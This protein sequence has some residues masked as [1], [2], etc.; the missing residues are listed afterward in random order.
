[1]WF[2]VVPVADALGAILAHGVHHAGSRFAKGRVIS[3][4]D[5][6][7][8]RLSG[9]E[10]ITVA[11]LEEGDV[12]E[13]AAASRLATRLAGANLMVSAA[14]TGRVNL[15]AARD[16]IA[17]IDAATINALNRVD[18]AVTIAT[19]PPYTPVLKGQMLATI[20]IIPFGVPE[21][22]ISN[23]EWM[24][25]G[26]GPVSLAPWAGLSAGLIQTVLPGTKPSVLD[27]S[28]AVTAARMAGIGGTL[29]GDVRVAHAVEPLA[30]ALRTAEGAI[31]LIIGAS[32]ITDRRDVIPAAIEAAGGTVLHVGMPVDPGNLL[33]LGTLDGRP[34]LGLPGCARSPKLNGVDWV[35]QRLGAGLPVDAAAIM[36]MGVGGL[37][38]EI[39]GRPLPRAL[40]TALPQAPRIHGIVLA[41]GFGRRM[42]GANKLLREW[43]GEPLVRHVAKSALSAQLAGVTLVTGHQDGEVRRALDGLALDY[44]HA[45]DHA[46][47]MAATLKAGLAALP[48]DIDGVLI[49]LGDMPLVTPAIIN[50]MVA[51]YSPD[52]GRA[53][54]IPTCQGQRGNPVLWDVSYIPEMRSLTGDRG[55]RAL[56]TTHADRVCEV[57]V[58]DAGVLLDVDVAEDLSRLG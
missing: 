41:G 19:V 20:K 43:R 25:A 31:L 2:G 15:F 58:E 3:A 57:A 6:A 26:N 49:L 28:V 35:L 45:S 29:L 33:L 38:A 48:D 42:G 1:M 12:G 46:D 53:I 22:I 34:V 36:G 5:M 27:K 39:A 17:V 52:Q 24:L 23:L 37:L 51:A 13:D 30:G 44:A 7:Q 55:A 18:E 56:L 21:S 4:S 8:L 16:G 32:A 47:G 14:H 54:I 9:I 11:R 50:R 40:A 10:T